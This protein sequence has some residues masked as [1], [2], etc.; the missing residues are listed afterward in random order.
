MRRIDLPDG[1]WADIRDP[2]EI[3]VRGRRPVLAVTMALQDV[4]PALAAAQAANEPLEALGLSEEQYETVMRLGE[5]SIVAVLAAWS[6]PDP[7]PTV[8][9][10][11]DLPVTLYDALAEASAPT[12][13]V[14]AEQGLVLDT[15][16]EVGPPDPKDR[17]GASKPSGKRSKGASAPK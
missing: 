7:L 1:Q 12:G 9:T 5:V 2:E 4:W 11:G 15:S 6:L 17:S 13:A 8:E 14:I 16:V 10:V 3:T